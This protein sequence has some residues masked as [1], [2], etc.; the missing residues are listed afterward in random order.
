MYSNDKNQ[1]AGCLGGSGVGH[2]PSAQGVLPEFWDCVP[3]RAPCKEPTSPS[4]YVP[5]S[6]SVSFMNK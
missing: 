2:L 3:H 6:H 5:A 4:A 1:C